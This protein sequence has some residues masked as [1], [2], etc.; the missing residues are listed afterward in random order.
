MVADAIAA[1]KTMGRNSNG[2]LPILVSAHPCFDHLE[3]IP[4][5]HSRHKAYSVT[6]DSASDHSA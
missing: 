6:S 1:T 4:E 2:S 5:A 3:R